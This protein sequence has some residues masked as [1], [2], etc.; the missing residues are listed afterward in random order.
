MTS[1]AAP[2]DMLARFD[3]E[4]IGDLLGQHGEQFSANDLLTNTRL[5]TF[6]ADASGDIESALM[7]GNRYTIAQLQALTGN[8]QNLLIRTTCEIALA[9]CYEFKAN[10]T[11]QQLEVLKHW[12]EI[13]RGHLER[14]AN[15]ENVF[16]IPVTLTAQTPS[17][18]GLTVVG[19]Q[20]L[21]GLRD[22]CGPEGGGHYYP[23]RNLPLPRGL[24]G[25]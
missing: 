12:Q 4:P 13:K 8:S 20:Q 9:Y 1:Y 11:E 19:Y 6:L 15:G 16:N 24:A 23:R 5:L 18:Q 2:A 14:L 22:V 21:N 25:F 3:W 17:V 10:L 7:V